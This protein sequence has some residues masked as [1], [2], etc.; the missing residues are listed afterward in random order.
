MKKYIG[1]GLGVF[2]MILLSLMACNNVS[3]K[4]TLHP[5]AVLEW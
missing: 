5:T 3:S 4:L 1:I 2:F